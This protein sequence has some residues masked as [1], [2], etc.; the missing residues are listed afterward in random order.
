MG[1]R[2]SGLA[3]DGAAPRMLKAILAVLPAQLQEVPAAALYLPREIRRSDAPR[4]PR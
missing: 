1:N 2:S 3:A 4:R